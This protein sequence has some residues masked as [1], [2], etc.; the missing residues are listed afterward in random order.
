MSDGGIFAGERG[1]SEPPRRLMRAAVRTPPFDGVSSAAKAGG[2]GEAGAAMR[3]LARASPSAARS[4]R[5]DGRR[6]D[7]ADEEERT[8]PS[9]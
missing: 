8:A 6:G 9:R 5:E 2:H 1:G 3:E 7:I 4:A